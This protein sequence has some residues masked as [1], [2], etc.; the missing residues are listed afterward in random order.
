MIFWWPDTCR[1]F[2]RKATT[3]YGGTGADEYDLY[4]DN[5]RCDFREQP[6]RIQRQD[7][8]GRNIVYDGILRIEEEILPTDQ[9]VVDD[10]NYEVL[11]VL[12]IKDSITNL[13]QY[14]RIFLERRTER[15]DKKEQLEPIIK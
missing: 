15:T 9:I 4:A 3:V 7:S 6:G 13:V 5:Q 14:Y 10:F 8:T 11:L 1:I 2:R 12:P